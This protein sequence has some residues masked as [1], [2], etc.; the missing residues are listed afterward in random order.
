[1][2]AVKLA[3]LDTEPLPYVPVPSKS[4]RVVNAGGEHGP[5]ATTR[6]L[7]TCASWLW[8]SYTTVCPSRCVCCHSFPLGPPPVCSGLALPPNVHFF[9]LSLS[10][11]RQPPPVI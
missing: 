7:T 8:K 3:L 10:S 9:C 11:V 5:G 2:N 1:M 6:Q 4:A